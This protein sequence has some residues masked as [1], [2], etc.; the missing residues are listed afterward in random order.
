MEGKRLLVTD[1][2][3]VLRAL[4]PQVGEASNAPDLAGAP[5]RGHVVDRS[6]G[7]LLR[8]VRG[9][10]PV[11]IEQIVSHQKQHGVAFGE[12]AVALKLASRDD[13]M[14]ALSKQFHYPYA[15]AAAASS[16]NP[17]LVTALDP[18][19]EASEM[20]RD[21]R[22]QL[23]MGVMAPDLPRR[24]LAVL[25]PN[26]GDGKTFFAANLAVAFSQLGGR[27]LLVDADMRTPRQHLLFN[28]QARAG[29]S[30]ILAGRTEDDVIHELPSLPGLFLL[31]AGTVPPN[32]LELIQRPSFGLLLQEVCTKFDH[33]IIDS[34]AASHGADARVT[35]AVSGAALIVG[36]RGR[37]RVDAI[38]VLSNQ[39]SK[40]H[41]RLAGVI[42]NEH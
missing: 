18:F 19:D 33:V 22:A 26:V 28:V 32:P 30:S 20:F 15:S 3:P 34:P 38:G 13:V 10:T 39:I 42:I 40:A 2:K 12:A 37:S 7:D 8:E 6:I 9:L 14:W 5:G 16:L 21:V 31:P 17:E 35:A 24:G 23:L 36:R 41:V 4:P 11:Q 29:L 25:S 27:T 1:P